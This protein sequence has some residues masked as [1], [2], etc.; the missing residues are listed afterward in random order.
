MFK[1]IF[2]K[3]RD[4][5]KSPIGMAGIGALA[6]GPLGLGSSLSGFFGSSAMKG[7]LGK[8][9]IPAL[10]GLITSGALK[11]DVEEDP[12]I[13]EYRSLI[14]EKYGSVTG[15][16]PHLDER[17]RQ[18]NYDPSTASGYD[19]I[20]N[21]G[22]YKNWT[23]DDD[24]KVIED[25]N[26][27]TGFNTGGI[28]GINP[29]NAREKISGP[30]MT[31]GIMPKFAAQGDY[32]TAED[33]SETIEENP[34]IAQYFPRQFGQISGP[35]GPKDDMIPAMLSDGEFVMTAKA[36]DNAG[37]PQAMY[38]LMNALDPESSKGQ[39]IIT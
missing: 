16:S 37:G 21:Q 14:D 22:D 29:F 18:L 5:A 8:Y 35:G 12:D 1:K 25:I 30:L 32:M 20:D 36:V 11:K 26:I 28:A 38:G 34:G 19:Y 23:A 33:M 2:R 15:G 13:N 17:F 10:L 31:Q 4:F 9:G 6:L 3:V 7:A 39:G 24:G 27:K